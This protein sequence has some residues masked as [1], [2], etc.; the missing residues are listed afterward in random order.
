MKAQLLILGNGFDLQCGLKS[1]YRDFFRSCILDTINEPFGILQL[2]P[3]TF[4]FWEGLML[5]YYKVYGDKDYNWC[6]IETIIKDTLWFICY[7]EKGEP[8]NLDNGIWKRAL[9]NARLGKY[10]DEIN[11]DKQTVSYIAFFCANAFSGKKSANDLE[12]LN[13]LLYRLLYELKNF[14]RRF[15]KFLKDQL[16]NPNNNEQIREEYFINFANLLNKITGFSDIEFKK[17][18][19]IIDFKEEEKAEKEFYDL[20]DYDINCEPEL[21]GVFKK[22]RNTYILS[23]NYTNIFDF[24][25]VDSPCVYSN[26]H[27]KL[28]SKRHNCN[29]GLSSVIFGI[30]DNL[31]QSVG[32]GSELRIFSKTYRKMLNAGEP[33]SILPP[34]DQN[35]DIIFYGHS[36]S[37]A[38]YSYFQSIF[39]YYDL[40]SNNNVSLIFYYSKGF[41]NFDAVYNLINEYGGTLDNKAKGK[42]LTHKLLLENR[43]SIQEIKD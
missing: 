23:F 14:E 30:D 26:V 28:C 7:G 33:I 17:L 24:L 37:E 38:D 15:C 36:L 34:N 16:V 25:G 29:C 6:D 35:V 42:N 12:M 27:G 2:K 39:D 19:E 10:P 8:T 21:E 13:F 11:S 20:E 1:T 3:E 31:I 32:V 22:L 5:E 18:E 4:G 41:E 9:I 43:L 40:Y